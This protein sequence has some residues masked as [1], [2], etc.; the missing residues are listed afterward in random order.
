MTEIGL[1]LAVDEIGFEANGDGD[2]TGAGR[3]LAVNTVV[4]RSP[5]HCKEPCVHGMCG[6]NMVDTVVFGQPDRSVV[7][8]PYPPYIMR[9]EHEGTI[10]SHTKEFVS[11]DF[12]N[13][14]EI[15]GISER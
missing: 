7:S 5:Q 6:S 13:L 15:W 4:S 12:S 8:R 3:L 11:S 14:A 9:A 10:V 1:E 2:R